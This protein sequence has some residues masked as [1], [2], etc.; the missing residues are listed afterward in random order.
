LTS[1]GTSSGTVA[2]GV[3]GRG[4]NMKLNETSKPTASTRSRVAWKSASLSPGKPTMKSDDS[5]RPGRTA[6]SRSTLSR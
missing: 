6:R 5:V 2:A 4:L 3:P 1:S